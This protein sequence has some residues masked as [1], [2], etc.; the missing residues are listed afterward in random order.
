[1]EGVPEIRKAGKS[2]FTPYQEL[3]MDPKIVLVAEDSPQLGSEL[4]NALEHE[5][6]QKIVW[7]KSHSEAM[8]ILDRFWREIT[9]AV[10][11]YNLPDAPDG[12]TISKTLAKKIPT[13]AFTGTLDDKVR[14]RI[15][16]LKVVDYVL[17]DS[18]A[19][20]DHVVSMVK[21]IIKN[22]R[23]KTLVVDDSAPVR[24][25]ISHLLK[26]HCY[27]VLTA[28]NGEEALQLLVQNPDIRLAIVDY[29]MPGMDGVEL[30]RK[31]RE[32]YSR[33][34]LGIIGISGVGNHLIVAKF[35]KN[36]A[37][38][39]I[40]K[41]NFLTEEFYCRISQCMDQIEHVA[42]IHNATVK[43]HLTR[44]YN[45][46]Y[47]I[48]MGNK[49]MA[50]ARRRKDPMVVAMIDIDHFKKIN[51]RFGH[52]TGDFV[53]QQVASIFHKRCRQSDIIARF[54]GEEFCF[55][56]YNMDPGHA[57]MFFDMF[58]NL[59]ETRPVETSSGESIVVTVSIGVCREQLYNLEDMIKKAEANLLKAKEMGRN[60]VVCD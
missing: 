2:L 7:V 5:T 18:P 15:L 59:I 24:E 53:L 17:K 6:A 49:M 37:N 10:V 13:I 56:A 51:A 26:V 12:E 3:R 58:C 36:G 44:L 54:G 40:V 22:K 23:I 47:F 50:A 32:R 35:I 39:F 4:K 57:D 55:L 41:Q 42:S 9:A 45:R 21:R 11:N 46:R 31:I 43:D 34:E 48:E 60:Q 19:S 14:D 28:C 1:M 52:Q 20:L 30:I 8:D 16:A 33:N 27:Q 29:Q 25:T 38:D